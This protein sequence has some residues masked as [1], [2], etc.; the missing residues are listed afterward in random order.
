MEDGAW[1]N[2]AALRH[3][4]NIGPKDQDSCGFYLAQA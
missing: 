2:Q 4:A 1:L 3:E